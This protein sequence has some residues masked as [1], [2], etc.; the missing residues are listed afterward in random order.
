[1]VKKYQYCIIFS[2][3]LLFCLFFTNVFA[4]QQTYKAVVSS[5]GLMI[6]QFS[7]A[8]DIEK[9]AYQNTT[10]D[11][12]GFVN[13]GVGG[14]LNGTFSTTGFLFHKDILSNYNDGFSTSNNGSV[15]NMYYDRVSGGIS[16]SK[17]ETSYTLADFLG[18][19][20][21]VGIGTN[22]NIQGFSQTFGNDVYLLRYKVT[23]MV[24]VEN[25]LISDYVISNT[26]AQQLI[27]NN[28]Y[29]ISQGDGNH[30]DVRFSNIINSNFSTLGSLLNQTKNQIEGYYR[31]F[32]SQE[33]LNYN[34]NR[35]NYTPLSSVANLYDNILSIPTGNYNGRKVYVRHIDRA[36][37]NI[38]TGI[39]S[40]EQ[41]ILYPDGGR[42][43]VT[44]TVSDEPDFPYSEYYEYHN[45]Y[46]MEITKSLV[47]YADGKKYQYMGA[48]VSTVNSLEEAQDIASKKQNS[49]SNLVYDIVGNSNDLQQDE[50]ATTIITKKS[51]SDDIT[52]VDFYYNVTNATEIEAKVNT[53][54]NLWTNSSATEEYSTTYVP[55]GEYLRPYVEAPE[56]VMKDLQYKKI[57]QDGKVTY[58]V[59]RFQVYKLSGATIKNSSSLDLDGKQIT[60]DILGITNTSLISSIWSSADLEFSANER[61][62]EKLKGLVSAENR[63]S[64]PTES[65]IQSVLGNNSDASYFNSSYQ[66]HS[67]KLNG[68][69]H[70]EADAIYYT[71]DVFADT[72]S[73]AFR[74]STN[75]RHFINVYTPVA[76]GP[77]V[78]T[79]DAIDHTTTG[80]DTVIEKGSNF[81]V[82]I[83]C[84]AP[85][86]AYYQTLSSTNQYV[87]NYYIMFDFAIRY[88]GRIIPRGELIEVTDRTENGAVFSA[89]VYED[90]ELAGDNISNA[91]SKAVIFAVANNMPNNL[92]L[93]EIVDVERKI[94]IEKDPAY[95]A[96]NRKYVN[97]T[98]SNLIAFQNPADGGATLKSNHPASLVWGT[99]YSDAYYVAKSVVTLRSASRLYDFRIT[100]CTD[101]AYKSVFRNVNSGEN[102]NESTGISYYSGIR[103][104]YIYNNV[105]SQLMDRE[106]INIRG[107]KSKTILPL[108]P[109]KHTA[110]NYL[111]APKL[112]Y[113]ISFDVKTAGYY[114]ASND[115]NSGKQIKITPSYYYISKDGGTLIRNVD[116]YYK[117]ESGK[118]QNFKNSNYTIYFRPKDSYR[119]LE[120]NTDQM[121]SDLEPLN[122][123][124]ADGS[125]ILNDKMMSVSD[126]LYNQAWYGEFKLPNST[127]VV[128]A[129]DN[130][131]NA[132]TDGYIGVKFDIQCID[133]GSD[134]SIA[135][136]YNQN[137]KSAN[138]QTNTTQ[139]DYEGYLGFSSL[140]NEVTEATSLRLQLENG[141]WK[142]DTDELYNFVKGTV[143]LFDLDNRAADDFQ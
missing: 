46:Q 67:S 50:Q 124:S 92:L 81:S 103:R 65:E 116:L 120:F 100:D 139:W 57:L 11:A 48:N 47:I 60:G 1:M 54:T 93:N 39:E 17:S 95:S 22:S 126:T 32:D 6:R 45:E 74:V 62:K 2:F 143:V 96:S 127:I 40:N 99:M 137:D 84:T 30:I 109:Y 29:W 4:Y 107:T 20:I 49:Y 106:N 56:Y 140:G 131:R 138:R 53:N 37:G 73:Y 33:H 66:V 111:N 75:N 68:L 7:K 123:G 41:V 83:D 71:Y 101:L 24:G 23:N 129:G 119:A 44:R 31:G 14:S 13:L 118:Y 82:Y 78:V 108:G 34:E 36:T 59:E 12:S 52:I 114:M 10:K 18:T 89:Q 38:I 135:T 8:G 69:R 130:I 25:V 128:R 76:L 87:V 3:T 141:I 94:E 113:R 97:D 125:F 19:S 72:E 77:T 51:D 26:V 133:F 28:D 61:I 105:Y 42:S 121:S 15:M 55:A 88:N 27:N 5:D 9:S 63:D 35:E 70:L 90:Q 122:L 112:G 98:N 86:F 102:I 104:L 142:I 16:S 43:L 21:N 64:L 136:S 58:G 91:T 85:D 117:D 134:G 115:P 79:S 132:L 110:A 80:S